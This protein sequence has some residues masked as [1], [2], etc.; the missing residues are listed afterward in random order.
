VDG[1]LDDEALTGQLPATIVFRPEREAVPILATEAALEQAI[2]KECQLW[3]G[4]TS[5][6]IPIGPDGSIPRA[7]RRILAG[8]AVDGI[9][10]L[11][12]H[13]LH[14]LDEARITL[15]FDE[16]YRWA[17]FAM[18][19]LEYRPQGSRPTVEVMALEPD[20]PWRGIYLACLG[21]LPPEPDATL[22]RN[23]NLVPDLRF[24]DFFD[25][26]R[27]PAVGSLEDLISRQQVPGR[28]TP[29]VLSMVH[30]AVGDSAS[31]ALRYG[32][33]LLP[34]EDFDRFDAGP[35]VLVV[36]S[37]ESVDD[38]ALLWNLRAAHGDWRPVPIGIPLGELAVSSID[39]LLQ[40]RG[41]AH[42]GIAAKNLY[43]TSASVT[44]EE[45]KELLGS[46]RKEVSIAPSEAILTLGSG[47]GWFREEVLSW[48]EGRSLFVPLPPDSHQELFDKRAF[49]HLA[50]NHY[51][52]YVADCPLP[53]PNDLRLGGMGHAFVGG[54]WTSWGITEKRTDTKEIWWPTRMRM[55]K[56]VA[57]HR[58]LELTESRPGVAGRLALQRLTDI[59]WL[60]NIAHAP[61]LQ[62]LE[63]MATRQ[64]FG[65]YKDRLREAGIEAD[66]SAATAPSVDDMQDK[67]FSD[68]NRVLGNN[69]RAT[70]YWLLWAERSH[71][72]IKGFELT[73]ERCGAKQWL[74][75][76][77]FSPPSVC[78][79]CAA[80]MDMPF[81]D[82]P[83]LNFRYRLGE[84]LRRIYAQDAMGHLLVARHFS[85]L[86][87]TGRGGRLIGVHP[88]MEV[89][90]AGASNPLGEADV[91][92]FTRK[93]DFIPIEVKRSLAGLT[94]KE[95]S[96]LDSLVQVFAAP[97][98]AVAACQYGREAGPEF[99]DLEVKAQDGTY[100]RMLLTYDALLEPFAMW[101]LGSDPFAWHALTA[102]EVSERE[103]KFVLALADQ[104]LHQGADRQAD[105]IMKKPDR[106]S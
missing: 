76:A 37:P 43:V 29:R 40:E 99:S 25:V 105:W 69:E 51:R 65:W 32:P 97:W 74:S 55:A 77:A 6:I 30:L 90:P 61:L 63:E 53:T 19:L 42:N 21:T 104:A 8:S 12:A 72:I 78:R 91:L 103:S 64:G 59:G 100:R 86:L 3:G 4:A 58:G 11:H 35:N 94:P 1:L 39:R 18:T 41:L 82:R 17:Q 106:P 81:G 15:P 48:K 85:T 13:W 44:V 54:A 22:M 26:E 33:S 38:L 10:G 20:D 24:E 27:V 52:V 7:Y 96:K 56:A 87:G 23:A 45:L 88:G 57:E 5:P 101:A 14:Y 67:S 60:S 83:V 70:K 36:C 47:G 98:S 73:C 34:D 68:F 62:L 31:T 16:Q 71:L 75:V 92:L 2:L 79:A 84:P 49:A 28:T 46:D 93:G 95:V 80:T 50:A 66:P 102:E 89:R 9:R